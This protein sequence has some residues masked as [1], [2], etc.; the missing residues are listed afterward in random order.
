[1]MRLNRPELA[2]NLVC[3]LNPASMIGLS[4]ASVRRQGRGGPPPRL[5]CG[6]EADAGLRR[7]IAD[8]KWAQRGG[9]VRLSLATVG[10]RPPA[11]RPAGQTPGP[12]PHRRRAGPFGPACSTPW[13]LI[14]AG[15]A[16]PIANEPHDRL[17]HQPSQIRTIGARLTNQNNYLATQQYSAA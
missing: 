15:Y 1:M 8:I 9:E 2:V 6:A 16:A 7:C 13:I 4:A 11:P 17:R 14:T 3:G 5:V 10:Q 12:S